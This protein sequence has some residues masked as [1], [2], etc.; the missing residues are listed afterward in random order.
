MRA[1]P[2]T[3]LQEGALLSDAHSL[4]EEGLDGLPAE[5]AGVSIRLEGVRTVEA[6][7]SMLTGAESNK[8]R[9]TQADHTLAGLLLIRGGA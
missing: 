7:S 6:A 4:L 5:R 3:P 1:T 2:A 8:A 9:R